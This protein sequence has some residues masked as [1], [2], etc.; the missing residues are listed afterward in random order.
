MRRAD[1]LLQSLL[2]VL[3]LADQIILPAGAFAQAG[4]PTIPHGPHTGL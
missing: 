3:V 1:V 4:E 2:P